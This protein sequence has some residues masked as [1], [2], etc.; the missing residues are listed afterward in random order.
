MCMLWTHCHTLPIRF[1][2][3]IPSDEYKKHIAAVD[4]LQGT[5]GKSRKYEQAAQDDHCKADA[6]CKTT[7]AHRSRAGATCMSR[8]TTQLKSVWCSWSHDRWNSANRSRRIF[9]CKSRCTCQRISRHC[10]CNLAAKWKLDDVN[11]VLFNLFVPGYR[12]ITACRSCC[13]YTTDSDKQC[14]LVS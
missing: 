1:G 6:T 12:S 8:V 9:E 3:M 14:L 13:V 5:W 7:I 11:G 4:I 10:R 2:Y